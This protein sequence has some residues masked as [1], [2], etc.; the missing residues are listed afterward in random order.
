MKR[1]LVVLVVALSG[2]GILRP[3][4]ERQAIQEAPFPPPPSYPKFVA[5]GEPPCEVPASCTYR[6]LVSQIWDL[7]RK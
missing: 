3:V 4:A 6:V 1:F 5:A 2:C 7:V